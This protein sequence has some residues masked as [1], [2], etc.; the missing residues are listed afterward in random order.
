MKKI[1]NAFTL[2]ELI[3][4]I[5]ITVI[6][7]VPLIIFISDVSSEI[8]Y[9]NT[10]IKNFSK[11]SE[12]EKKISEIK[13]EY[14]SAILLIDN[15]SW[16]GSDVLLFRTSELDI[17]KEWY[18]FAQID[19]DTLKIDTNQ[20]INNIWE[21][22]FAYRK[23]SETELSQLDIDPNEVYDYSFHLDKI[24]TS[25]ILKDFQVEFY[26]SNILELS[27][28]NYVNYNK[29]SL[30]ENYSEVPKNDIKEFILNF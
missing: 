23:I 14:L 19:I 29:K 16:S 12:I 30:L 17:K 2:I 13:W 25:F 26:N 15:Q 27:L 28:Y 4:S 18:I 20:N 22:Y 11:I 7:I 8:N 1:K 9:S 6:I 21:K 3:I 5:T 24:F 10:Q